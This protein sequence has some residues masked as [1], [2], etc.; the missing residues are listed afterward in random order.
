PTDRTSWFSRSQTFRNIVYGVTLT[1]LHTILARLVDKKIWPGAY[2]T[3]Q[4]IP[5][6]PFI[7]ACRICGCSN[8][9]ACPSRCSW[10]SDDLCSVCAATMTLA[11]GRPFSL[12]GVPSAP[13]HVPVHDAI[14]AYPDPFDDDPEANS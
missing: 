6:P 14:D 12:N 4:Y 1:G 9:M 7:Q 13:V 2:H 10:H 3:G 8:T 5:A 11:E